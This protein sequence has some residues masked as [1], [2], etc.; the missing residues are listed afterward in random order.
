[1]ESPVAPAGTAPGRGAVPLAAATA[2]AVPAPG[3][4]STPATR[5]VLAGSGAGRA[6]AAG[7]EPA[8]A[9]GRPTRP[10]PLVE[11]ATPLV[12]A[13]GRAS[14]R[15]GPALWPNGPISAVL[16]CG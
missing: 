5:L 14:T 13:A 15:V 4:V 9:A 11:R 8:T 16:R 6:A 7:V 10:R 12:L 3:R 1:M 2:L